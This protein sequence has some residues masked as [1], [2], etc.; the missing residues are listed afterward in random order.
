MFG[1]VPQFIY[2]WV[3]GQ[4]NV[5]G[6]HVVILRYNNGCSTSRYIGTVTLRSWQA[7]SYVGDR[8]LVVSKYGSV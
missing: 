4:D 1:E 2:K 7:R 3:I 5:E 6:I 8:I